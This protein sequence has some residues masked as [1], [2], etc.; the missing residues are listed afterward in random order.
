MKKSRLRL[1][2]NTS[3]V[4]SILGI[5]MIVCAAGILIYIGI[6]IVSSEIEHDVSSGSQYDKLAELRS[7]YSSLESKFNSTKSSM[8][9]SDTSTK[10]KYI[11]AELE[12][13]RTQTA[14]NNVESGLKSKLDPV[15]IDERIKD[16]VNELK[17]ASDTLN[18]L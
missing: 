6:S 11:D 15:E 17:I 3:M 14:I 12:L 10:Q 1:F 13:I 9:Q 18:N 7:K 4:I 16:A 5:I 2:K 8:Y